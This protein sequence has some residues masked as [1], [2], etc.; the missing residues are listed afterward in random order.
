MHSTDSD[1]SNTGDTVAPNPLV[2][3]AT[4]NLDG[5]NSQAT[6]ANPDG[7]DVATSGSRSTAAA[8]SDVSP[9]TPAWKSTTKNV[10]G[11]D[12]TTSI[13]STAHGSESMTTKEATTW[14]EDGNDVFETQTDA[15]AITILTEIV[16]DTETVATT[17]KIK[18]GKWSKLCISCYQ[19]V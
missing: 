4:T 12:V 18:S 6:T 7:N 14:A 15:E 11:S 13:S 10:G 16:T 17:G 2:D 8:G 1:V 9:S 19:F 5:Y 3:E